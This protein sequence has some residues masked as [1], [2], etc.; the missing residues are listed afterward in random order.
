[1]LLSESPS[2]SEPCSSSDC[3]TFSSIRV[4]VVFTAIFND[5]KIASPSLVFDD[6]F[7]FL[8]N[9]WQWKSTPCSTYIGQPVISG[10]ECIVV[11]VEDIGI[12]LFISY[13]KL[14][15]IIV[16]CYPENFLL[17]YIISVGVSVR[18]DSSK[19]LVTWFV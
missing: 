4:R 2:G 7:V 6:D 8:G 13:D 9:L 12:I 19:P 3:S 15:K 11:H 16:A 17:K 18:G 5:C 1:M 10:I 14:P